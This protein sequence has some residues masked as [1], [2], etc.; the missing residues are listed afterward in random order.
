MQPNPCEADQRAVGT[1]KTEHLAAAL[2]QDEFEL[3]M[4]KLHSDAATADVHERKVLDAEAKAYYAHLRVRQLR[5]EKVANIV[6]SNLHGPTSVAK[7]YCGASDVQAVYNDL[8]EYVERIKRQQVAGDIAV[9]V[10]LNWGAPATI[11]SKLA[12]L[13]TPIMGSILNE[14]E[15]SVGVVIC[16]CLALT[17]G[18]VTK[19]TSTMLDKLAQSNVNLD[20][21]FGLLFKERLDARDER[22]LMWPGRIGVGSKGNKEG[23]SNSWLRCDLFSKGITGE[24]RQLKSRDML[25]VEAFFSKKKVGY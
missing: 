8:T 1:H 21:P 16:P 7:F 15:H 19:S 5:R 6:D 24:T 3:V 9:V 20:R 23:K 2:E 12:A 11:S 22:P 4:K 25:K 17:R 18:Q 13:Q 10:L 14:F